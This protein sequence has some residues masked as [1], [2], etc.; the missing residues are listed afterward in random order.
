MSEPRVS[1]RPPLL[2]LLAALIFLECALLSAATVYLVVELLVAIPASYATAI[3]ILLLAALG[4]VWLGVM[5]VHTVLA[6]PWIRG[7]AVVWQVLQIAIAIGSFQGGFARPDL[8]WLLISPAVAVLFLLF[9]PSVLA[10]TRRP[11]G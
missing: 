5:A 2:V 10:A 9:M 3:A 1:R 4:A 6:R 7:A 11:E 8:G